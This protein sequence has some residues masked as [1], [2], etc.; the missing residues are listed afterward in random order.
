MEVNSYIT[1]E[2][3]NETKIVEK[4]SIF[5]CYSYPIQTLDEAHSILESLKTKYYIEI[6]K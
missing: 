5:N 6:Y 2:Q 3:V 4:G 1:L